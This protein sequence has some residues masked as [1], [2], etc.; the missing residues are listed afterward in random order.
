MKDS[1]YYKLGLTST[2]MLLAAIPSTAVCI[3]SASGSSADSGSICTNSNTTY[4]G[5]TTGILHS[6][7]SGSTLNATSVTNVNS[8]GSTSH[9]VYA[10]LGGIINLG[11]IS[12]NTTGNA[13]KAVYAVGNNSYIEAGDMT[14]TTSN[15]SSHGIFAY[16]NAKIKAQNVDIKINGGPYAYGV[17]AEDGGV[18]TIKGGKIAQTGPLIIPSLPPVINQSNSAIRSI[19]ATVNVTD[20]III[21]TDG[22][23][24]RGIYV[25]ENGIVNLNNTNITTNFGGDTPAIQIGKSRNPTK[26]PGTINSSGDLI[27]ETKEYLLS[28]PIPA[29]YNIPVGTYASPAIYIEGDGSSLNADTNTSSTTITVPGRAIVY[30]GSDV[31]SDPQSNS[32]ISLNNAKIK[33][34]NISNMTDNDLIYVGGN[35]NSVLN[36]RNSEAVAAP[37]YWLLN[38]TDKNIDDQFAVSTTIKPSNFVFNNNNTTLKGA[39]NVETNSTLNVNLNNNSTWNLVGRT[40]DAIAKSSLTT[41]NINTNSILSV[42][43]EFLLKGDINIDSSSM[44]KNGLGGEIQGNV[45]NN[46]VLYW[47]GLGNELKITGNYATNNGT[48]N[49]RTYLGD[50][51]SLT[52]KLVISGNTSGTGIIT[53]RPET[54]S[55]GAQTVNGIKIID[56]LGTSGAVFTLGSPLQA[57]AYEYVLGKNDSQN[58][59]LNSYLIPVTPV[60]PV[61]PVPPVP[62][63]RPGTSN[64]ISGQEANLEQGFL[65]LGTLHE[66]MNE[67]QVVPAD[68]QTWTRYY[69]NDESNNGKSRFNYNQHIS[70]FQVGQDLYSKEKTNGSNVHSGVFFDYSHAEVDFEDRIR[71][72]ALLDKGTGSMEGN[73]YGIGG[74]Y[75]SL[76]EDESYLDVVGM[77]SRLENKYED[78]YN[79]KSEQK[80]YRV[81]ISVEAGKKIVDLGKWKLEGQGQLMYQHTN[82]E[83]FD[84][85]IS[86]IEGYS[87]DSLRGRLGVRVYR[88]L[89]ST[90]NINQIDKAQVYGVANVIQDFT[91]PEDVTIGGTKVRE[92]YDRT[93][94]EVGGGFQVPISGSTYIYTDARYDKSLNGRKEEGKVTIGF[95]TQF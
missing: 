69:G 80:G 15:Y 20:S 16:Q 55:I 48:I 83:D 93:M 26:G 76:K 81:G 35:N 39:I 10:E 58:W 87:S 56:V 34:R 4:T 43:K 44:L 62:I 89:E 50:D 18:V 8:T 36:L 68:N 14:I 22:L 42:E 54:G 13:S 71:E 94:L 32:V 88:H 11:N 37:D 12:V 67:Q 64:Y 74:Y 28:T 25:S 27:I 72:D 85:E 31:V 38:V 29:P 2:I 63:Y 53:V 46:G 5:T 70:A 19:N 3:D 79:M 21:T 17:T 95:K 60:T 73:S 77:V 9:A 7:G 52:D 82:Y 90:K 65:S 24:A 92:N 78:S 49:I 40:G 23:A 57:G 41:L 1:R 61:V 86:K 45:V 33:T 47:S 51:T 6:T 59:Y 30:G 66:R 75:T 91:N 84:D